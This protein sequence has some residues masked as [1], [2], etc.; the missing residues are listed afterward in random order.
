MVTCVLGNERL[1]TGKKHPKPALGI[2]KRKKKVFAIA[3]RFPLHA[4]ATQNN[5]WISQLIGYQP[6]YVWEEWLDLSE[7]F[8]Q[9]WFNAK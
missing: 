4:N 5:K 6:I 2:R 3:K 9:I 8:W 1:N 7:K